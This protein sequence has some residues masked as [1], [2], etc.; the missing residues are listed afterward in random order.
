MKAEPWSWLVL[1]PLLVTSCMST[2]VGATPIIPAP[3]TLMPPSTIAKPTRA[4]SPTPEPSSTPT[5]VPT[6]TTVPTATP[7]NQIFR[8]DFTGALQPGW[9]WE[10]ENPERWT[11]TPDGWLQILA[12]DTALLYGQ[13]QSNTLWR[14][15]PEGDFAI[16]VHLKADP[17]ANFQQA[18]LYI[19][20]NLD[21]YVAINRGFCGPCSTGGNEVYME[22]KI[23][24][25]GGAYMVPYHGTDLYLRLESKAN[26]L[27]GFYPGSPDQWARLG[28]FGNYFSFRR[29]GIGASNCDREGDDNAD[30]AG[31]FDYFEMTRL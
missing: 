17:V 7:E 25:Q 9:T 20:E 12:E 18:A 11:F 1:V 30:L 31:L 14:D 23:N 10:N 5:P 4:P 6:A 19:F 8:D 27:S 28:R 24:R 16:T 26:A 13:I 2:P 29:V 3:D 15:L 22:Y 21:N